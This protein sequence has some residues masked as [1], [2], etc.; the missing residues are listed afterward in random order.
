VPWA[1]TEVSLAIA[2]TEQGER[3]GGTP[4]AESWAQAVE[5][6]KAALEILNKADLPDYWAITQTNM[7]RVLADQGEQ[8]SGAQAK[9]LF[10]RA[11]QASRDASEVVSKADLSQTWAT[12]QTNLSIA[13]ADQGDI[14]AASQVLAKCVEAFPE[15]FNVLRRALF[16]EQNK[17]YLF[18]Q[19]YFVAERWLK[20]D[21]SA[22][23]K[24][25]M[26]QADLTTSRFDD[27]TKQAATIDDAALTAPAASFALIRDTMKMSCQWGA[28]QKTDA[29]KT[30][31][32]LLKNA[33]QLQNT[34]WHF[35]GARHFFSS[36]P[37]F[38]AGRASWIALFDSLERGNGAALAD[39]LRQLQQ[40]MQ[41]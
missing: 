32:A 19:T 21:P 4:S 5:A 7:G 33:A 8:S 11:L 14:A 17:L 36:S 35:D 15:D 27:C 18:D 41:R 30:A 2:L 9:D 23:T 37:T 26:E 28:G 22:E 10:A 29:Q 31:S 24:L 16:I 6:Y 13:L 40:T 1:A 39:A 3:I 25:D 38:E 20:L 34:G 12:I